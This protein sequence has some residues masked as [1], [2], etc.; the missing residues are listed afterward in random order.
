MQ[1][2][3]IGSAPTRVDAL[4]TTRG[5]FGVLAQYNDSADIYGRH[6][7]GERRDHRYGHMG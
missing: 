2:G 4:V 6:K 3:E 7:N 5:P 1:A